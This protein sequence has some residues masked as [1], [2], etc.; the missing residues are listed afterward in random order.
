MAIE[1][2]YYS[3]DHHGDYELSQRRR[4]PAGGRRDDSDCRLAVATF[5]TLNEARDNAILI[6]T[7]FSGTHQVWRDVYIGTDHA[8]PLTSTSSSASTR[9][10]VD[11]RRPAQRRRPEREHRD[12]EVPGYR[13]GDN[14]V[15]QEQLL[16]EHFGIDKLA[17]VVGGSMGAQ[18]TY[19]WAVRFRTRC[20]GRRR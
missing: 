18:Q 10:A 3:H 13:I 20:C 9:S 16:R 5:G 15:A 14:V 19:E 7:W 6:P 1:N 2:G 17:L 12:V 8:E 4:T 11:C